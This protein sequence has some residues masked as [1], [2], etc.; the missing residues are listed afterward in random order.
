MMAA[1][2]RVREQRM[3]RRWTRRELADRADLPVE[4]VDDVEAADDS[5]LDLP[6]LER[7]AIALDVPVEELLPKNRNSGQ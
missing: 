7:L 3:A 2:L 1:R 4:A 5:L 6:V